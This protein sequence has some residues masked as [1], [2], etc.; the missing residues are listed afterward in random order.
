MSLVH[1]GEILREEMH[2]R[3]LSA[4]AL[5]QALDIPVNRITAI[6]NGHQGVTQNIARRLSRYFGTTPD[7]WLNLQ[8]T[9]E[10]RRAGT[11]ARYLP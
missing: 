5:S 1:P 10:F 4:N 3:S 7:F 2:E 8:K 6:L 11:G 9:G